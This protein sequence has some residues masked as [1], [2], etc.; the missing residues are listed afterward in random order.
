MKRYSRIWWNSIYIADKERFHSLWLNNF[1]RLWYK[2]SY[3]IGG[4][5][6]KKIIIAGVLAIVL[7]GGCAEFQRGMKDFSSSIT[8]L[9]RVA[10]VYSSDGQVIRTFEGRFDV[11]VSEYGNKVK[12]DINGKRVLIYNATVIIE[13]K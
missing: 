5:T 8:G 11:E 4:I 9:E 3:S 1:S 2:K 6:M 7:L 13:E 10:T 12:F